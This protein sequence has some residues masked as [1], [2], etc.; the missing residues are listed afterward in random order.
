MKASVTL[1]QSATPDQSR[2]QAKQ[3][4]VNVL[5]AQFQAKRTAFRRQNQQ[6]CPK[7]GMGIGSG[8]GPGMAMGPGGRW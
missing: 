2:I 3:Q 6:N 7:A 4:E 1:E 5:R 8:A